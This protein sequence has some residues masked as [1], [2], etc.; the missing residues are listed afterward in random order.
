MSSP[1]TPE[2]DRDRDRGQAFTLEGFVASVLVLTA[3]LLALQSVVL[4]PTTGGTLDEG[5][6]NDLRTQANDI[7]V[8]SASNFTDCPPTG[9]TTESHDLSFVLRFWNGTPENFTWAFAN[10]PRIGYG[11]DEPLNRSDSIFGNALNGTF[12]QRGYVYNVV[13]EYRNATDQNRSKTLR[14]VYRGV[15]PETAVST[16][17][18]VTLY[19]N[20]TLTG[21]TPGCSNMPIEEISPERGTNPWNTTEDCFYPIPEASAFDDDN[22]SPILPSPSASSGDPKNES[23]ENTDDPIYNLVEIRVIV[24]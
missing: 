19:D 4:T 24:W 10:G 8:V 11:S 6:Q 21:P 3:I 22:Q 14:L 5:V 9:C 12:T 18:T 15:P 20:Q 23:A 2:D 13:V 1:P 7:L 16:T 17:Y